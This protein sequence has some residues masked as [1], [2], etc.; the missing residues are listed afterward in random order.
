MATI[1][2]EFALRDKMTAGFQRMNQGARTFLGSTEAVKRSLSDGMG[3]PGLNNGLQQAS[4]KQKQ[5]NRNI[6]E[7][8]NRMSSLVRSTRNLLGAYLSV[9]AAAAAF[10]KV[11]GTSDQISQI[12]ARLNM[13]ND[14][15][16]SLAEFNQ[17]IFDTAER[18]RGSYLGMGDMIGKLGTQAGDAFSGN[19]E[20]LTF[21]DQLNKQYIISG[22]TAQGASA[23]TLQLT[24]ALASGV[25]RGEEFNSIA[26]NA[27]SI[28]KQIAKEM[29]VQKGALKELAAEGEISADIVK[30]A[31]LNSVAE[32]NAA[33]DAM[34]KRWT[35]RV[36]SFKNHAVKAF[37]PVFMQFQGLMNSEGF[38]AG[39]NFAISGLYRVGNA[40]AFTFNV[41]G[42]GVEMGA[43]AFQKGRDFVMRYH[44]A[45]IFTG[46][47]V[48]TVWALAHAGAMAHMVRIY[49][50][51]FIYD[52]RWLAA[53]VRTAAVS[54]A[55]W[56][57]AH[58]PIVL[59]GVLLA[60][61]IV[62]L[63]QTG[64]SAE[65]MAAQ[66]VGGFMYMLSKGT[67]VLI[68]LENGFI[69]FG[70][71]AGNVARDIKYAFDRVWYGLKTASSSALQFMSNIFDRWA[72]D[73]ISKAN[74]LIGAISK[75]SKRDIPL[76]SRVDTNWGADLA[77][78]K[79]VR[80]AFREPELKSYRTYEDHMAMRNKGYN[81]TLNRI[82]DAKDAVSGF[83]G[84][85]DPTKEISNNLL[86]DGVNKSAD[87]L[88]DIKE[89]TK[90]IT[91]YLGDDLSL[92]SSAMQARTYKQMEQ[93]IVIDMPIT[94]EKPDQGFDT[95]GFVNKMAIN[96]K[97]E[98]SKA[99]AGVVEA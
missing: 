39:F 67:N 16:Q 80:E 5:L 76:I 90:K 10:K 69:S 22:T 49:T 84:Q 26:E 73:K 55:A 74:M 24:Q 8:E 47:A 53:N 61:V 83:F 37:A 85:F 41:I 64:L 97:E 4:N 96:L 46:V 27:P 93:S 92:T 95:D 58:W 65:V 94:I 59:I 72:N 9:Q 63:H 18:A 11:S 7:G 19:D 50:A 87:S 3:T 88:K 77:G 13:I 62:K 15:S 75:I 54:A 71:S 29:G 30:K 60:G 33:F 48:S 12:N 6:Q 68:V 56:A 57:A 45:I 32:T 70:T 35:D 44:D 21:A 43:H 51:A 36:Q 89:N 17:K 31:L 79:P 52:A 25:L 20:L 38:E 23:A 2:T 98:F 81:W 78:D 66:F 14:G 99:M 1:T 34:P 91:E 86:L 42:K 40:A 28:M 82:G